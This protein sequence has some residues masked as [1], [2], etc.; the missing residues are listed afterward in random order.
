[1][2]CR[3]AV[4]VTDVPAGAEV[5]LR[6]GQAP[7]D[8]P[9]LP[10]GARLEF[11]AT[12]EGYAPKR[13]VVPAGIAWDN[14][15][16]GKP[17]FELGVQLDRSNP[18]VKLGDPWPPGEP[19]SD[20]GGKGP[21][22]TVHLISTPKGAELWML[23]GLGPEAVIEQR[24][25]VTRAW[26]FWWRDRRRT[27]RGCMRPRRTLRRD[28]GSPQ[29]SSPSSPLADLERRAL[30]RYPLWPDSRGQG[31]LSRPAAAPGQLAWGP[32]KERACAR[33]GR[34]TRGGRTR[35]AVKGTWRARCGAPAGGAGPG[36]V[37]ASRGTNIPRDVET[38]TARGTSIPRE[39]GVPGDARGMSSAPL[40]APS[41]RGTSIPREIGCA[42]RRPRRPEPAPVG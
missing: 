21:P 31:E 34:R 16:D 8:V 13:V 15:P 37:T 11:V 12:A 20:V 19:G 38:T 32:R 24:C 2:A 39:I 5:L 14:G 18:K 7:V 3:A 27:G 41:A 6:V 30:T 1:M 22:G 26:T 42:E 40:D 29:T 9:R 33:E 28:R 23:G 35:A 10:V 4:D 25:R 17:R 36:R